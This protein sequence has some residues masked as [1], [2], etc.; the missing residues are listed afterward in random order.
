MIILWVCLFSRVLYE[1][2]AGLF[3]FGYRAFDHSVYILDNVALD[4]KSLIQYADY[5]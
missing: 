4:F 1:L 3:C 2:Y 5:C